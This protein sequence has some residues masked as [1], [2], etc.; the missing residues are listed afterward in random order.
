MENFHI[1]AVFQLQGAQFVFIYTTLHDS[2]STEYC[3]YFNHIDILQIT[4]MQN[5]QIYSQG[6][7][8]EFES[9]TMS[10]MTLVGMDIIGIN[11][12]AFLELYLL[13]LFLFFLKKYCTCCYLAALW[14]S[15]L[16]GI[17]ISILKWVLSIS[18]PWGIKYNHVLSISN[19]SKGTIKYQLYSHIVPNKYLIQESIL[20]MY[21][22]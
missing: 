13:F 15:F 5:V 10:W 14:K 19:A 4:I 20:P 9:Y 21:C 12:A 17:F 3:Q 8:L 22:S 2:N 1:G 11:I 7:M 18:R 6:P 16:L